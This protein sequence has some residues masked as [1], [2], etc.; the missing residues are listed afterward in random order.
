MCA[1]LVAM[2]SHAGKESVCS[3]AGLHQGEEEESEQI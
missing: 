3:M 1:V 2:E